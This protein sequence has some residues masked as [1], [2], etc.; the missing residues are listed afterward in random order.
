MKNC[1][2]WGLIHTRTGTDCACC[3]LYLRWCNVDDHGRTDV[4]GLYAIGE[5]SYPAYTALTAWPRIHCW[6]VWSMLVGGGRY[7]QTYALCPRHQYVPPWDESRV[8]N[9]DERVVIQHTGTSYVCL[10]GITLALC[11][12]RRPGTRPAADNHAPTRNRRILP[13]FRVSNNLLELR[14]L[15]QVAE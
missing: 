2:G 1:S 11:A 12:Q 14:N 6:S 3:T 15:V 9:P 10:C 7:H 5:V 4:E 8:E 13:H